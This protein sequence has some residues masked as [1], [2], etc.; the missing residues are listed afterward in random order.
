[1][2]TSIHLK[3]FIKVVE[4]ELRVTSI[5][6][7]PPLWFLMREGRDRDLRD[8]SE[9]NRPSL[10]SCFLTRGQ[11]QDEGKILR[12]LER[13][14]KKRWKIFQYRFLL[15]QRGYRTHLD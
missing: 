7:L 11:R 5:D 13:K 9:T 6:R 10:S 14:T 15:S 8:L 3:E 4:G 2:S 12:T 1:M